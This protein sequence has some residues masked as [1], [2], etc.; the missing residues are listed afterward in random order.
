MDEVED[1]DKSK[2]RRGGGVL[3]IHSSAAQQETSFTHSER[4]LSTGGRKLML[5]TDN[6]ALNPC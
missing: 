6:T 5:T 1:E 4:G 3:V 2:E